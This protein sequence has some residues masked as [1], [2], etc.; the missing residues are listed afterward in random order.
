MGKKEELL[1]ESNFYKQ[2][3][4]KSE[5]WKQFTAS[6]K[7]SFKD[8]HVVLYGLA[9]LYFYKINF[10]NTIYHIYLRNFRFVKRLI[11]FL[12]IFELILNY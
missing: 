9:G 12:L 3:Y 7:I 8:D 2:N 11:L 5:M 1:R 10:L 4:S 6:S